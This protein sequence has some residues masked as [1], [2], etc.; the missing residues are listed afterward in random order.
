MTGMGKDGVLGARLMK[1]S[2][3]GIIAQDKASSVVFG[4]PAEAIKADVVDYIAPLDK[5][6]AEIN[7][8][9]IGY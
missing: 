6:A 4:M 3:A 5:I 9:C 8:I 1:R 2:G 7:R